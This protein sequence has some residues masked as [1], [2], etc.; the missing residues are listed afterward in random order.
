MV[1]VG[2][3]HP[4][5]RQRL[6]RVDPLVS[7]APKTALVVESAVHEDRAVRPRTSQKK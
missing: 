3:A 7:A 2:G 6:Q 4:H 1:H 5:A